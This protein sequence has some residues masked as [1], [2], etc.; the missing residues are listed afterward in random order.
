MSICIVIPCFQE[1]TR[2]A[3][4]QY[5]SFVKQHL[6][7]AL[8][9]VNDGSTDNTSVVLEQLTMQQPSQMRV[10]SLPKNVGKGEAVRQGLLAALA[11]Q[12]FEYLAYFDADLATPLSEVFL[13]KD[14]LQKGNY[15]MAFGSRLMRIGSHIERKA[16]RHYFGRLFATAASFVI[17]LPIYD[18]QCGAKLLSNNLVKTICQTPFLSRWLFDLE[19]FARIIKQYGIEQSK[20]LLIE[21]PLRT[22]VEQ[23]DSRLKF[24]HLL[25]VP[26]ELWRI[27]QQYRPLK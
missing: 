17:P 20:K 15:L 1:G 6:E 3:V 14:E 23:G 25:K 7:V 2:L 12:N 19:I 26:Y 10:L 16:S 11:W 18:T 22:W 24:L 4:A 9:F 27:K 21:V 8:L 13:L 5:L